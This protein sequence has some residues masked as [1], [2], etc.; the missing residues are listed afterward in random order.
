MAFADGGIIPDK[1]AFPTPDAKPV[2][3]KFAWTGAPE[4][5]VS[6]VMLMRDEEFPPNRRFAPWY[7]WILF[8][9]PGTATGLPEG[10]PNDKQLADGGVQPQNGRRVGYVGP[11]APAAGLRHHYTF[12]LYALDTKLDLGPEATI[13]EIG[14]AMEGHILDKG[15]YVGLYHK[16]Q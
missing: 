13:E 14:K 7:H 15:F 6:F 1:Y 10:L 8:N 16:P 11:G 9:I 4:G 5:T 2:S 12:T 3:P